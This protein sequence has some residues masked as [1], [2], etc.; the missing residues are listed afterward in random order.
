M[1]YGDEIPKELEPQT[2]LELA[3]EN[4]RRKN[5][6]MLER[7]PSHH[8]SAAQVRQVVYGVPVPEVSDDNLEKMIQFC[9]ESVSRI[10]S[11]S[12]RDRRENLRD[13][14]D[15]YD[16]FRSQGRRKIV[17]GK[18]VKWMYNHRSY[19]S[20]GET[21]IAGMTGVSAIVTQSSEQRLKSDQLVR[22]SMTQPPASLFAGM[23]E[24]LNRN[25]GEEKQ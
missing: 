9:I 4:A 15:I 1:G 24:L 8:D 3:V 5:E 11:L 16:R 12:A 2:A 10:P 6:L 25:R 7:L 18:L 17:V 13:L 14:E 20:V 23:K 21:T 19:I 22:S